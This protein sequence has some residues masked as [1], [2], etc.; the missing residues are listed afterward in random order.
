MKYGL[1]AGN[2]RFPFLILQSAREQNLD[3]VV[4]AIKEETFPEIES[5]GYPVNWLGLGELGKLIQVFRKSGVQQ[6]IMAG[7]V[8][9]IQIFGSSLPDLT[10]IRM[11]AGLKKKNTDSLIGGIAKVL[12]KSGI[13]LIDSTAFLKPHLASPGVLT[14]RG[15]N[16]AEQSDVDYGRPLAHRIASMDIGQTIAVR[17]QAV[18]AVEAMEGTDAVIRRAG[19]LAGREN[20][21]VI[22]VSKPRQDMRFDIPVIGLATIDA[23]VKSGATALVIDAGRALVFDREKAVEA[24]DKNNIAVVAMP[25]MDCDTPGGTGQ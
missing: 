8:K 14:K 16:Q 3:V 4:A 5:C 24:A 9:H 17:D 13:S 18:I 15:L 11:L 6:A 12:E 19:E 22:K 2:G 23:M 20:I 1:I 21:T 7:Q 25:P 10:M